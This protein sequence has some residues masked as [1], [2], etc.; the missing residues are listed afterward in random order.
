MRMEQVG[1][2]SFLDEEAVESEVREAHLEAMAT[3][4][5]GGH[6]LGDWEQVENGWQASCCRCGRTTWIGNNGLRYGVLE[7]NCSSLS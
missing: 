5:L 4:A 1:D 2:V 3:A 6:E 7:D